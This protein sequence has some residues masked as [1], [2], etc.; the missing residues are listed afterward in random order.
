MPDT[1]IE[2]VADT[3]F[4]V[5]ME[6]AMEGD[7][8]DALFH[9][10]LS[11]K[12]A[13]ERGRRIVDSL[14]AHAV[15]STW[16]L[17]IRTIII[18]TYIQEAMAQGVT[19]IVNLG[20]GL[21]TRPYRMDLPPSLQWVEVDIPKIIDLKERTLVSETP[22]CR[23]ERIR[24]DLA[25]RPV[26]ARLFADLNARAPKTLVITEGVIPYLT[27][28][29]VGS[30]ADDLRA[31][32]HFALWIVDYFSP[33]T[34]KYRQ[35]RAIKERMVNAP[36]RFDP[37]DWFGFLG[38][39]RWKIKEIRY[40]LEEGKRRGRPPPMRFAMRVFRLVSLLRSLFSS[41]KVRTKLKQFAGYAVLERGQ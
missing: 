6:R 32:E 5:A 12:L 18:D 28:D 9:D 19:Q 8:P 21:D 2:D 25:D 7:R 41:S 31:Q 3:A 27:Q 35:R 15:V 11:A 30:L 26:R 36:W 4:L 29:E 10:P 34:L 33:L 14:G 40:L 37:P 17:A 22:R 16:T 24:L 39:H 1:P 38:E 20:A 13:G 23:L